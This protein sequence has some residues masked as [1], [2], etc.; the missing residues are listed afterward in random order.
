MS[1]P[2]ALPPTNAGADHQN[3][4]I[5][6]PPSGLAVGG[7]A[8]GDY[9]PESPWPNARFANVT[10]PKEIVPGFTV[11]ST[12]SETQGTREM[13]EVSLLAK[14]PKG[15]VLFVGCSHPG[16]EKIVEEANKINPK[17]YSIF[18]GYH[19]AAMPDQE[20]T[21]LITRFKEKWGIERMSA[22]HCTGQFA[23]AEMIRI[24]G[25]NFD[26]AGVGSVM[27]LPT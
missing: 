11:F 1:L 22:G 14:T 13:N 20:V 25:A 27:S 8:T 5:A 17:I 16:I 7:D 2:V 26:I 19:L 6:S 24:Y 9:R 21:A 4:R 12:G 15:S 23:F 10:E 18:G 3:T